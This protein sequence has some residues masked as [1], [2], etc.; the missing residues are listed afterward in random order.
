MNGKRGGDALVG[1]LLLG[2][3]AALILKKL[4]YWG[5]IR[6]L[7]LLWSILLVKWFWEGLVRREVGKMFFSLALFIIANDELLHLE[8]LTPGTVLAAAALGTL[9]MQLLFPQFGKN[10][11]KTVFREW[12]GKSFDKGDILFY[13][14]NFSGLTKYLTGEIGAL[15]LQNRF[16]GMEIFFHE[17]TPKNGELYV[18][19]ESSFG[20]VELYIPAE[21][22]VEQRV[23][24]AFGAVDESGSCDSNGAYVVYIEGKVSF[25]ALEIHYI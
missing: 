21:W 9:G 2:A 10:H 5:E 20:S 23:S 13:R 17:A 15:N 22:R 14:N 25:G 18:Y 7:P 19:V 12:Q 6:I 11:I 8:A 24:T 3:A 4:G 16:G 1:I